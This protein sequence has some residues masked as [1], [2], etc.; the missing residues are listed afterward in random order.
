MDVGSIWSAVSGVA[1][2]SVPLQKDLEDDVVI[3]GAGIT[4]LT[5]ALLLGGAGGVRVAVLGADAVASGTTGASTGNLYATV[6]QGLA[7]IRQKWGDT[8]LREVVGARL[9][10][11][12][13]IRE[14]TVRFNID[15][16]LVRSP[17]YLCVAADNPGQLEMLERER[18]AM[19]A[20]G[21]PVE[22]TADVPPPF[23]VERALRL[24]DQGQLNPT[25]YARGLAAALP[26]ASCQ[27]YGGSQVVEFDADAG[28]VQTISAKVRAKHIVFATHTPKGVSLLHTELG[29]YREYGIAARVDGAPPPA[30]AFWILDENRSVRGYRSGGEDYL[31]V[32]GEQHKTGHQ[33]ERAHY[34]DVLA[35]YAQALFGT[36]T[37]DYRW[38]AQNYRPADELPYIGCSP[39][40]DNI[41][42]GT[43]YA[44]SGLVYGTLAGML[45]SDLIL[46][47]SNR[48]QAIFDSRRFTPMK[49]A[50]RLLKENVQVASDLLKDYVAPAEL[51]HVE[52]VPRGEGRI[53]KLG[54]DKTAVYRAADDSLIMLSPVCPHMKCLVRWNNIDKSWDC[55]CHGSRFQADGAYIEGPALRG[56]ESRAPE[57]K[58]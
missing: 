51:E 3:V 27:I 29:P 7:R 38:S 31:I 9:A 32:I 10:A 45:I 6:D 5:A 37:P 58:S 25:A 44:T 13:L 46:E 16:G 12:T 23:S 39:G 28:V 15:C 52:E 55:P 19:I 47:R 8:T 41:Y 56:L 1:P 36:R 50:A 48:W 53:V 26:T 21:L 17:L 49:S 2:P 22:E 14:T 33:P 40:H 11:M 4:G 54:G 57:T 18:E 24:D 42:V 35:D 34:Y 30:G 20:A 43:G